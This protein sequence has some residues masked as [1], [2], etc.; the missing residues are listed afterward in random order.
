MIRR[1]IITIL[2]HVDHGKTT[3]LDF[4]RSSTV[5][6][7]EAGG[8]TQSIGTTEVPKDQIEKKCSKILDKFK[9]KLNIPGLLFID[10]PGHE[11]FMTM[12]QR[13]GSIADLVVLLIDITEGIKAQ[14]EECIEI[15]KKTKTP[16]VVGL[17]KIDKI[18]GW[19]S[20]EGCFVDNYQ[21]QSKE[22]QERF[23]Q[24]FYEI[25]GKLHEHGFDS[26][27][28]DKISDFTKKIALVPM[29]A[30]NGEGVSDLLAI[31]AGLSQQFLKDKL[32]LNPTC[33]GLVLE[34]KNVKGLGTTIDTVIYDGYA[35]EDSY[36]VIGGEEPLI[37]KVKAFL[38]PKDLKD[39][40]VEKKFERIKEISAAKGVKIVAPDLDNIF[41]GS[42][43]F[44]VKTKQEAEEIKEKMKKE[45]SKLIET[46]DEGVVLKSDTIGSLEALAHVFKDYPIKYASVGDITKSDVITA[47]SNNK[48]ENKVVIGF[49]VKLTEEA[50]K[51]AKERKIETFTSDVIYYLKE[52]YEKWIE[53]QKTLLREKELSGTTRPAFFSLIPGCIFRA[54]NPAIV[55]A[56]IES[57]LL[58]PGAKVVLE[59]NESI[60][61]EI[62]QIQ[63]EGKTVNE[64]KP[65]DKVALS[66]LD[67]NVGR[68]VKE[69]DI[70]YTDIKSDEYKLLKKN[71]DALSDSEKQALEK[72]KQ[73]KQSKERFWGV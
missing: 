3:L 25:M 29:S 44:I 22:T 47:E 67:I 49:N 59:S 65:G 61:G 15:L 21:K 6:S 10:T 14:T 32:E 2:A 56:Q 71:K 60:K 36:I 13:G 43:F 5:A 68:Q 37:T 50:S 26:E 7:K 54:N 39:I 8:I 46:K 4:I 40:R 51:I 62:K 9:I 18:Y 34:V 35:D 69:N 58:K 19:E 28:Y 63:I 38:I 73:I 17:N 66:I 72:I 11:S 1:P 41:A 57:G 64:A 53:K 23:D 27:R 20:K 70:F 48:N 55:G 45:F 12:R 24:H 52:N 42:E 30:V 16:F 31:L 33:K